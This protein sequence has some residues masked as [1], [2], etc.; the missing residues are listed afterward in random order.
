MHPL[1]WTGVVLIT[2]G[3]VLILLPILGRFIDLAHIPWWLIYV[4][5]GDGFYFV[6]SPLLILLF[7]LSVVYYL[8]R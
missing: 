1:T 4:Y 8:M 7:I 5:K 3:V 2:I 6:T